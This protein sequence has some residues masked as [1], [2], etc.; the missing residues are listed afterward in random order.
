MAK[1]SKA[2]GEKEGRMTVRE[3]F[4]R[5][6]DDE[7]CLQHLMDVRYGMR[8]VCRKCGVNSTFHR[9]ADRRAFSCANCGDH[10]YPTA[11]TIFQDTRTPLQVWF[12][13][14]YLFAVT[15]H[16]VS[17]KE[18][19]RTLGVTYKTAWRM[20]FHI[21][22]LMMKADGFEKLQGFVEA[23]KAYVG[24]RQ[25]REDQRRLGSNKTIVMG[26][27]EHGGRMHAEPVPSTSL[28]SLR[29]TVLRTVERGSAVST[30]EW[31]GY[32]LL[33]EESY[34][35]V[36]VHHASGEYA[37]SEAHTNH[38]ES[39]WRLFK[40]SIASTHIHVSAKYMQ[41]YLREFTFR[42][43]HRQMQN[44]MFDLLIACV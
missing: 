34:E 36:S 11:G 44:A 8:H 3:F 15:R 19:E 30:D 7:K 27:K 26:L 39:F 28:H 18:L 29:K 13:A 38:V 2:K 14:I 5:W 20:A 35:H 37:R 22:S 17:G 25:S 21:R 33:T 6:S 24:C 32:N 42:Q 1:T 43:N 41:F 23:D 4:A 31:Q 9:L 40:N 10:V 16:S 12:Y